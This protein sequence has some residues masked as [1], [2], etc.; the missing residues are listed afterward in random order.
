[1]FS[2]N[3]APGHK[4][5]RESFSFISG[6]KWYAGL[7]SRRLMHLPLIIDITDRGNLEAFFREK[8]SVE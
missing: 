3:F 5:A 4:P 8:A 1:M 6:K 7:E 2:I